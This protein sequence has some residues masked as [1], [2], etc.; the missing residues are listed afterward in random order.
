M[1]SEETFRGIHMEELVSPEV[2]GDRWQ[3]ERNNL[4]IDATDFS[5]NV[6]EDAL[7]LMEMS[8]DGSV[9]LPFKAFER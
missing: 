5:F 1:S 2:Y 6:A 9:S 7:I 8:S 4:D 3:L